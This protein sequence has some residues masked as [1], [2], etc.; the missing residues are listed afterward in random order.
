MNNQSLRIQF[1]LLLTIVQSFLYAQVS[2]FNL[3][4]NGDFENGGSGNGFQ[5]LAPYNFLATLTGNS[6]T[7][8]YA[9]IPNPQ[10]MNTGFFISGTDHSGSGKMMVID[11]TTIGGNPRFWKA[12]SNGGG[13]GPLTVG[14]TYTFS[15]WI[16]SI[17]TSVVD[18]STTANIQVNWNNASNIALVSGNVLAPYPGNTAT[19]Q[20]VVYSFT[21][22][23]AYVNIELSNN[24]TNP[25]GNDFAIDDIEVLPPPQPLSIRYN[26]TDP[27]CP[28]ANNGFIAVYATGGTPP[29]TYSYNGSPYTANNIFTGLGSVTNAFVSVKDAASPTAAVVFSPSNIT[30]APP[31]NPLTI[32][33]DSTICSGA[34]VPLYA[35][36]SSSGYTWTATPNDPTI[37][38]PNAQNTTVTPTQN[39]IYTVSSTTT[40]NRNLIFNGDFEQGDA[41]FESQYTYFPF[42]PNP[43]NAGYAQRA[44]SI[45]NNAQQFEPQFQPCVD[46]TSGTGKFMAIDG[47]TTANNKIWS[48]K[49]G[50]SP[51]TNYTIQY[52]LQSIDAASPAQLEM[53]VNGSPITGNATSSTTT[54]PSATCLWQQVSYTW[55]SAANTT[56]DIT[57]IGRNLSS[58]G[59]DFSIDDISMIQSVTCTFTKTTAITVTAGN[60]PVTNFS[61]N[62][63][64]CINGGNPSPILAS[65][66]TAGGVFSASPALSINPSTGVINL[67]ATTPGTYTITYTVAASAC[68][69]AGSS[70]TQVQISSS[71]TPVTG[72]SYTSPVCLSAGNIN[73][74]TVVGFTTGGT[75]SSTSGLSINSSTGIINTN[76]S[77]PG[78]YT[79]TY[80]LSATS[81][82]PSAN[83]NTSVTITAAPSPPITTP[84]IRYCTN[85]LAT[86]LT[87][88]GTNLT[89]YTVAIGGT[90]S[91]VAP[92]PS[93]NMPGTTMYYV[94]QST[95]GCESIRTPVSVI[96]TLAPTVDAGPDVAIA[97]GQSITL[98]GITN[99][100]NP[101]I[102]WSPPGT[103]ND[104][105]ILSPTVTPTV[106]T[107]YYLY[108]QSQ[109]CT[110]VDSM[111][112][113]VIG[114]L[115]IPNVFSPNG[116]GI[117]DDWVIQGIEGYPNAIV[118]VYNRYGQMLFQQKGY[119]NSN[120][121]N[122]QV[123]GKSVPA[124]VY[125]YVI[126]GLA[127]PN[128]LTGTVTILR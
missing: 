97:P 74:N 93:T 113:F 21:A 105:N 31:A 30:L 62:S 102:N 121:W 117:H 13:V 51:N 53:Q 24:N 103:I 111:R 99:A 56:A 98:T 82:Q 80:S 120:A 76:A 10:P 104:P 47:A 70:S 90:G 28:N 52:W 27:S 3:L 92:T 114:K 37:N 71:I 77:T 72:F 110:A 36:G 65:G 66:F 49:V 89:W 4:V 119:N 39:T 23:T 123:N 38:N 125:F 40:R 87:A 100:V 34:T 44:Y 112:V 11:G 109:G 58:N 63:P 64:I 115:V 81:C 61:Y 19:W 127:S 15:Y 18:V 118:E 29:Y 41:G 86:P 14:Q 8:D 48:Q 88:T 73:P 9:I 96:V 46:H 94:S 67:A 26:K 124:G 85:D 17:A 108:I 7:G 2:P 116:D 16:K 83:S 12:G 79:V 95:G 54:A 42:P 32:R 106:T 78:T 45:V 5:T 35:S 59:N 60:T 101:S 69:S 50:V 68:Q 84:L 122:G 20:K 128:A 75:F 91:S 126:R 57:L 107:K 22:S 25:V 43:A 33:P 1:T 55:N 6:N